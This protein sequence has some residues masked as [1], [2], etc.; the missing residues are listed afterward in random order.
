MFETFPLPPHALDTFQCGSHADSS[1]FKRLRIWGNGSCFFHS[2]ACLLVYKNEVHE[3]HI[4]YHLA[5][6]TDKNLKSGNDDANNSTEH[7]TVTLCFKVPNRHAANKFYRNFEQ[8]GLQLRTFLSQKLTEASFQQFKTEAFSSDLLWALEDKVPEW[9]EVKKK[10]AAPSK[11][12]DIWVAKYAA[13]ALSLN[14]LF[15]NGTSREEPIFC[16]I[17]NFQNGPW[18]LFIFWSGKVHFEPIVELEEDDAGA[19]SPNKT[20]NDEGDGPDVKT[21]VFSTNHPF[22]QCLESKFQ[23]NVQGGCQMPVIPKV[24]TSAIPVQMSKTSS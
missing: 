3:D 18:T 14:L 10:L 15:I 24:P 2:V 4:V 6:P 16:G 19:L 21:K 7:Q 11:W 17:E 13:W 23:S 1:K 12:A 9:I 22:I 5:I 8:V 20:S